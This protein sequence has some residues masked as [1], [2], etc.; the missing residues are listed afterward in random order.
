MADDKVTTRLKVGHPQHVCPER[1]TIHRCWAST[2]CLVQVDTERNT[3][4]RP[5]R[6][7]AEIVHV[8]LDIPSGP[9]ADSRDLHMCMLL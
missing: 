4:H 7:V 2:A 3:I 9:H 6:Q 5:Q 1:N 8:Y